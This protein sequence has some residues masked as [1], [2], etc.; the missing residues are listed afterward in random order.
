MN[1]QLI[2]LLL[3]IKNSSI[4]HKEALVVKY[5]KQSEYLLRFLYNENIIQS[6]KIKVSIGHPL[7]VK[8]IIFLCPLYNNNFYDNLRV[9]PIS[10]NTYLGYSEIS[11]LIKKQRTLVFQTNNNIIKTPILTDKQCVENKVGG[12]LIFSF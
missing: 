11:K 10:K 9:A 5:S 7:Q 4:I 3:Q 2:N 6:Y 1:L 12:I 8:Y